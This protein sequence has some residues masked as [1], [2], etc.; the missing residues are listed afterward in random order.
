M[1]FWPKNIDKQ[2]IENAT[3]FLGFP[4]DWGSS[5]VKGPISSRLTLWWIT[6][7]GGG[8]T[9]GVGSGADSEHFQLPQSAVSSPDRSSNGIES[10]CA[11]KPSMPCWYL[12]SGYHAWLRCLKNILVHVGMNSGVFSTQILAPQKFC[13]FNIYSLALHQPSL[14]YPWMRNYYNYFNT[15]SLLQTRNS[16]WIANARTLWIKILSCMIKS[17]GIWDA[18]FK[19]I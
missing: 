4:P 6:T 15:K 5:M 7:N 16:C 9:R 10:D 13:I 14:T 18:N 3:H 8:N 1:P 11:F 2:Q 19:F 17:V 12:E